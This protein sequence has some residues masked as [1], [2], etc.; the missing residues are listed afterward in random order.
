MEVE[1]L[2]TFRHLRIGVQSQCQGVN[3]HLKQWDTAGIP[4]SLSGRES[5]CAFPSFSKSVVA[6]HSEK[7]THS[8][9]HFRESVQSLSRVRLFATP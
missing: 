8:E 3:S 4:W 7:Q 9:G 2:W 6:P 1:N 5:N